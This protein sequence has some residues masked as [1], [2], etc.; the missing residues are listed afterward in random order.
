LDRFRLTFGVANQLRSRIL[1]AVLCG[2][3]AA[4]FCW[5]LKL[6]ARLPSKSNEYRA[7]AAECTQ[8]AQ[9]K[10]DPELKRLYE[11]LAGDWMTL[12]EQAEHASRQHST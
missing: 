1:P 10:R 3:G 11:E 4:I 12:A 6:E 9:K 7:I 2:L 8:E 5:L